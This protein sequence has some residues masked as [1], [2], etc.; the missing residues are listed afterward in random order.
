M[1]AKPGLKDEELAPVIAQLEEA[2]ELHSVQDLKG[3]VKHESWA[4]LFKE[5][6]SLGISVG[7]DGTLIALAKRLPRTVPIV[8]INL[9][10]RGVIAEVERNEVGEFINAFLSNSYTIERR[11]RLRAQ[12][13]GFETPNVLNEAYLQRANFN[14]TPT[15]TVEFSFGFKISKRM[16]GIIISTPTGSTGYNSSNNGPLLY[17]SL[18]AVVMSFVMSIDRLP[19]LVVPPEPIRVYANDYMYLITDGQE[20]YEVRPSEEVTLTRGDDLYFVKLKLNQR[21]ISKVIK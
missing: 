6:I 11:L 14:V 5:S 1:L 16:D 3:V 12:A 21:Q 2:F 4:D 7:G 13:T 10:G 17:E 18:D 19:P 20:R 9:G 8:G 15:I